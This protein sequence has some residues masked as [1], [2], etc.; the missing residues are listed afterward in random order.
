MGFC[1]VAQAGLQLL[2]L[3]DLLASASQSAVI[4]GM[5]H[6]A[7]SSYM[8]FIDTNDDRVCY[9]TWA[10]FELL[11]SSHPSALVP[12]SV[13]ITVHDA[14][15]ILLMESHFVT[16]AGVQW[17]DLRSWQPLPP[18][19][20]FRALHRGDVLYLTTLL[21]IGI[22][23]RFHHVG[24]TGLEL[25]TSDD[26]PTSASQS[27][28]ITGVSHHAQPSPLEFFSPPLSNPKA[29]S[30]TKSRSVARLECRVQW[31]DLSSLQSL[32]PRLKPLFCLSP[33]SSWDYRHAPP[34]PANFCIFS[35]DGISPC[36]PGWSQ[37]L[38]SFTFVAQAGVQ[39][40]NI[41][42]LQ[43]PPP[44]FKPFSFFSFRVAGITGALHAQLI[45]IQGFTM[46]TVAGRELLT[47]GDPPTLASQ[48]AGIIG[49]NHCAWPEVAF[50]FK[51]QG[52]SL[53]LLPRLEC[54][55]A[56]LA[57]C[58]L[59]LLGSSNPYASASRVAGTT[60]VHHHTR[61][62]FVFSIDTGFHYVGQAALK[63]LTSGDLPAS[64]SQSVGITGL[65]HPALLNIFLKMEFHP[66]DPGWNAM[67][68]LS[69]LQPPSPGLRRFS[70][71][72]LP[73][74]RDY[75]HKPPC[76]ANFVFLVETVFLHV[77]QARSRSPDLKPCLKVRIYLPGLKVDTRR[78]KPE[79][80][81]R[82]E[83]VGIGIT[84]REMAAVPE[85]GHKV[86]PVIHSRINVSARFRKPLQEPCTIFLIANG[87]LINPAS[88]LLIPRKALNQWDH[89][90]QMVTEKITLR[91]GAV[92]RQGLTV[93]PRPECNGVIS[94]H[95][96][97]DCLD[98][99]DPLTSASQMRFHHVA[100]AGLELLGSSNLPALASLSAGITDGVLLLLPRLECSGVIL[101]HCNLHLLGS[102]D[103]P[104]SAS[105]IAGITDARYHVRLIFKHFFL[106]EMG[107]HHV[108]QAGFELLTS[109][110]PPT[111]ASQSARIIE[112][113]SVARLECSSAVSA[114]CKPPPPGLKQFS[115]LSLLSSWD[116]RHAPPCPA[117]FCVFS[118]VG[119]PLLPRLECSGMILAHCSLNLLGSSSP[120]TSAK[121]YTLEGKLVESGAELENGQFYV[122]VGRDKFK[123]LPYSE[124]LFD[125]STMR[126]PY[127]WRFTFVAQ[128]GVQ[129][130]NLGS[131][132]PWPPR[133]K[134]FSCLSLPSSWDYRHVAPYLAN[135]VFLVE[136]GF[137]Y[138][139]QVGLELPTSDGVSLFHQAG[140]QW[141]NL[142]SRRDEVSPCWPGWSPSLDLVIRPPRPPKVLGLQATVGPVG[143]LDQML[144]FGVG[145]PV[146]DV[147]V[148]VSPRVVCSGI[149][150][151]YCS[152]D[153]QGSSDPLTSVSRVAGTPGMR[154][155]NFC[156]LCRGRVSSCC[157]DYSQSPGLKRSACLG[158]PKC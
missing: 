50:I 142:G 138:V 44:G 151:V 19:F 27:A 113:P 156:V 102:S 123:K 143:L 118:I 99:H 11:S 140:V 116:Y 42:S 68:H 134:R 106:V 59:C 153:L 121:L 32:S 69:S 91:S 33:L 22:E 34:C 80:R 128:A 51:V 98:L 8:L 77:G 83:E 28:R 4:T 110:D 119:L 18:G 58:N 95:C 45:F 135:F 145:A 149:I 124:L 10:V 111:L 131:S 2:D 56:I 52:E 103:S 55:G 154:S 122:A 36:W 67:V 100:Q 53:T 94:A 84:K 29:W 6:H 133:F 155:H 120:P 127:G 66:C 130:C 104:A 150:M 90:L 89:V 141:H 14:N 75:R 7:Q 3:S 1:L 38:I 93:S 48:S 17:R 30:G 72:S 70:C 85:R 54:N 26:P 41:A 9:V 46:L 35:R 20:N 144:L 112:S 146:P 57:H 152:L 13:G 64:A 125:K 136:T 157:P 5:S 88:R 63:F 60:G 43:P 117:N 92:H 158:L 147:G 40:C 73:S 49:V 12:H 129:W 81:L 65:S 76:L 101:A 109:S 132:Q 31:R 24:Q 97:L 115:C 126:R 71:L 39:W 23:M 25:L 96:S 37:T 21:C 105:Q 107:F 82:G 114:H 16:Q 139:V 15:V 74:S 79:E 62:I 78:Q 47:S 87:D 148:T 137:L 61:L 86:K 108:G